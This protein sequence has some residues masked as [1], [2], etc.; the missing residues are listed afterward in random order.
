MIIPLVLKTG[1]VVFTD[2]EEAALEELREAG[3][4]DVDIEKMLDDIYDE[5]YDDDMNFD[6]LIDYNIE[7]F[8]DS[9]PDKASDR[10]GP[11]KRLPRPPIRRRQPVVRKNL[12][13]ILI[14]RFFGGQRRRN[15]RP[16]PHSHFSH[17]R[18]PIKHA[19]PPPK[20]KIV[21]KGHSAKGHRPIKP[22]KYQH[23]H[24]HAHSNYYK[25][26]KSSPKPDFNNQ[27]HEVDEFEYAT[28]EDV[29]E[30][31][32][33]I[34][35]PSPPVEESSPSD[36]EPKKKKKKRRRKPYRKTTGDRIKSR[37]EYFD[38]NHNYERPRLRP[39]PWKRPNQHQRP[40]NE[41]PSYHP[42]ND[43]GEASSLSSSPH[44]SSKHSFPN[45]Y[46]ELNFVASTESNQ[47][48]LDQYS[49]ES[50]EISTS[51]PP[52]TTSTAIPS[53]TSLT[54]P[55][56]SY[57]N[58]DVYTKK[59]P[60]IEVESVDNQPSYIFSPLPETPIP[61]QYSEL[62][63]SPNEQNE[64]INVQKQNTE[65]LYSQNVGFPIFPKLPNLEPDFDREAF[66]NF[67]GK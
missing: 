48:D 58:H 56:P 35:A 66:D 27:Y 50:H 5:Y 41:N 34:D 47:L 13:Q 43:K 26:P 65:S 37:P 57:H 38:G 61:T 19:R 55:Q 2:E 3:L 40:S 17:R 59:T 21:K 63:T 64:G 60:V 7:N 15:S 44:E 32:D 52:S 6:G 45:F 22:L 9:P 62:N 1:A 11:R 20:K 39:R 33:E 42:P 36:Y 31:L 8:E 23:H 10:G 25:K 67:K 24:Q 4:L 29:I 49:S 12:L 30:G 46:G 16:P 18:K 28:E 53:T 14:A 54:P 51:S